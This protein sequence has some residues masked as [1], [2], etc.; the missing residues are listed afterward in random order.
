[1]CRKDAENRGNDNSDRASEKQVN[2]HTNRGDDSEAN[3]E[4]RHFNRLAQRGSGRQRV[5]KTG[6]GAGVFLAALWRG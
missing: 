3:E 1:M 4:L 6:R 5:A 2:A